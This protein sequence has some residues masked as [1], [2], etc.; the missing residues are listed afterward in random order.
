MWTTAGGLA[1]TFGGLIAAVILWLVD[2]L[3]GR[4]LFEQVIRQAEAEQAAP[5]PAS[6][7][8]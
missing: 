7:V 4:D 5:G 6:P 1:V 8:D 3:R 2:K